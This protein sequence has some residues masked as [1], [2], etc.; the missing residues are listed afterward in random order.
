MTAKKRGA[1]SR[2][3]LT[4]QLFGSKIPEKFNLYETFL[5]HIKK[6]RPSDLMLGHL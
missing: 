2:F 5:S 1:L 6:V 4:L 3:S